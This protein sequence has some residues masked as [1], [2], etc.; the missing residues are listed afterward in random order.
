M[1]ALEPIYRL[2]MW[3]EARNDGLDGR[4]QLWT[5]QTGMEYVLEHLETLKG[6]YHDESADQITAAAREA[7][8][9]QPSRP[10]RR[11]HRQPRRYNESTLPEYARAA[12][13][14]ARAV[15]M[16]EREKAFMRASI[17]N[18]WVKLDQYYALLAE[19]P[20]F[21]AVVILHPGH[22][23]QFLE[24][25]WSDEGQWLVDAKRDL[26]AYFDRWYHHSEASGDPFSPL[27]SPGPQQQQTRPQKEPSQF[28]Q[29]FK[30]RK[31]RPQG[32]DDKEGEL[33]RYYRLRVEQVDDPVKWWADKR[34]D[35]PR[36]SRLALDIL[37]I[38]A[39]AADCE[40]VFSI[41]KLMITSQRHRL[42]DLT[43]EMIQLLR[44]WIGERAVRIGNVEV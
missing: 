34:A 43:I 27:P 33:Q 20:L 15:N 40:R 37:A 3:A 2:T 22:G 6:L 28:E 41:A 4:G 25:M 38:P 26:E 14:D 31:P 44:H 30:S 29:W 35:F 10:T 8:W 23:L 17:N 11:R 24:T 39:M 1:Q 32:P 19:S 12:Y 36:L 13:T 5:L 21:T 7:I 42:Q 9:P 18:A 16:Q